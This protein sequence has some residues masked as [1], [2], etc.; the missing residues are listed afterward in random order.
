[1]KRLKPTGFLLAN[2][3]KQAPDVE[4]EGVECGACHAII[5]RSEGPF[6]TEAFLA[7]R[8]KHYETSP[9]CKIPPAGGV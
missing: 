8:K 3:G 2:P 7:A 1:M 5:Y 6:N 4:G 9:A